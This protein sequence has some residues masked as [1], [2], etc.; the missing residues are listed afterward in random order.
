M[1]TFIRPLEN[2]LINLMNVSHMELDRKSI[3]VVMNTQRMI[4]F[5]ASGGQ[6]PVIHR[7][8]YPSEEVA[9][10][11]FEEYTKKLSKLH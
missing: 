10:Q 7:I 3:H 2:L 4:M 6:D 8:V 11:K 9:K 1:K 5:V